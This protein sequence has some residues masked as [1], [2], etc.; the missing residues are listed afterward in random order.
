MATIVPVSPN[1]RTTPVSQFGVNFS[2]AV[3]GLITAGFDLTRNGGADL[4]TGS[5]SVNT[6]DNLHWTLTGTTTLTTEP[7]SYELLLKSS[8]LQLTDA[9]GNV[10]NDTSATFV[11][12]PTIVGRQ[13]FYNQSKW[14]GQTPGV[15]ISDDAAI[16]TDKLPFFANSGTATFDSISSYTRGVNGIMIDLSGS[17]PSLTVA[18]FAFKMGNNNSPETW[19]DAPAPATVVVRAGAGQKRLRSG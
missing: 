19:V 2:E 17:H 5:Q 7:G 3:S 8:L 15:S 18:D 6:V 14:D 1:P 13:L 4:L 11:V 10:A 12:A 16:A 9:A